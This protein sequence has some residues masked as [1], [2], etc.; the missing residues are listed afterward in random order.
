MSQLGSV[1]SMSKVL[2]NDYGLEDRYTNG[3]DDI[4]LPTA[5][6]DLSA[7]VTPIYEKFKEKYSSPN[8]VIE[9]A[10][11]H[12]AKL[13]SADPYIRHWCAQVIEKYGCV[14]TEATEEGKI[15]VAWTDDLAQVKKLNNK[16][17]GLFLDQDC[18]QWLLIEK[19][20]NKKGINQPLIKATVDV[21]NKDPEDSSIMKWM[22]SEDKE[23]PFYK[24]IAFYV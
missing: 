2:R 24:T 6:S 11:L 7:T 3:S 14:S 17:V 23:K 19:G 18:S 9:S 10:I 1:E 15:G 22:T 12:L 8:H 21:E 20:E 16:P 5:P 13:I 4:T